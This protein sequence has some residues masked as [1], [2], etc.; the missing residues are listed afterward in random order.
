[1]GTVPQGTKVLSFTIPQPRSAEWRPSP[2]KQSQASEVA[3]ESGEEVPPVK[4]LW[5]PGHPG[6]GKTE[7]AVWAL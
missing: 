5:E 2:T 1:M 6:P 7:A 4:M 3:G